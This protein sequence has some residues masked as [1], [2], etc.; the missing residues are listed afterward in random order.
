MD[1]TPALIAL[2]AALDGLSP[3]ALWGGGIAVVLTAAII[4]IRLIS[5]LIK[6]SA[7]LIA[8]FVVLGGGGGLGLGWWMDWLPGLHH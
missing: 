1:T 6:A 3:V 2:P 4:V 5:A 8:S 7:R